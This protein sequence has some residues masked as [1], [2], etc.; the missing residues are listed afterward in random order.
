MSENKK[1]T[2]TLHE[3]AGRDDVATLKRL[4]RWGANPNETD[5]FGQ[6]PLF[7]CGMS[8]SCAAAELLLDNGADIDHKNNLGLTPLAW[9][10]AYRNEDVAKLLLRR[11]ADTAVEVREQEV[12][13]M[14]QRL[15]SD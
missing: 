3:A 15:K 2:T 5:H 10:C 9:S 6:T 14:I 12:R 11:G 1:M 4:L 13:D 8:H 7:Y